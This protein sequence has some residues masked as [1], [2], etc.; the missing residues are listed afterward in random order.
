MPPRTGMAEPRN[1]RKR[2]AERPA[3]WASGGQRPPFDLRAF[4]RAG[5][6]LA[7]DGVAPIHAWA[8]RGLRRAALAVKEGRGRIAAEKLGRAGRFVPSH[9][10][11]AAWV[12]NLATTFA[13]A[14]AT[15][16]RDIRRGNA[17]VAEI[18]LHL[19]DEMPA[20]APA[21]ADRPE[22]TAVPDTVAP[23]V[24]PEPSGPALAEDPL[25]A[26]RHEMAGDTQPRDTGGSGAT[27]GPAAPPAPRGP[28]AEGAVQVAGWM[29]GWATTGLALPYGLGRALWLWA[30]GRDLKTIGRED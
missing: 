5:V 13:H 1:H 23:V 21:L 14:S 25:A 12:A 29:T 20:S 22:A 9:L 3:I 7:R 6:L 11:V 4:G 19:W 30:G 26:I 10:R 24:L 18:A 16:D 27:T 8:A 15:A 28:L 17:L 2:G